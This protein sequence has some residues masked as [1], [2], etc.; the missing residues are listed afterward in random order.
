MEKRK[1]N[2]VLFA[3]GN[4]TNAEN[5]IRYFQENKTA[6]ILEVLTNNP[7]A[8]VIERAKKWNI[9][10]FI[11]NR[12]TI[13]AP[14][15]LIAH[16][17]DMKTD[18]I[19]LAGFLW[20]IP[21]ELIRQFPQKIINLHPALLPEFGGKGMYGVHVHEAV[22]AAGKEKSGITIHYVD[23]IYD[24]GR[25]I[26][27]AETKVL[28]TDTAESLAEKI[29]QLEYKHFPRVIEEIVSMS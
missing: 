13:A 26:F 14:S 28:E 23:E 27:Q 4:G 11:F 15:G 24:N 5:I 9:P 10:V 12:E 8:G 19:V 29:H 16:L 2:I 6:N 17:S 7:R 18:L 20:K 1:K 25:I 21:V 3:S 22:L